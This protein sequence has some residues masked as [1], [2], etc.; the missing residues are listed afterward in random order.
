MKCTRYAYNATNFLA[1]YIWGQVWAILQPNIQ[2]QT[3]GKSPAL[4][5]LELNHQLLS[6]CSPGPWPAHN[7]TLCL[8]CFDRC[9]G[10]AAFRCSFQHKEWI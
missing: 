3:C 8:P 5:S 2:I 1:T 9:S 7:S 6:I 10:K 4:G